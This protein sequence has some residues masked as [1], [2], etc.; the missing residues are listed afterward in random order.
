M[1]TILR[2]LR[3][4]NILS[5]VSMFIYFMRCNIVASP[6]YLLHDSYHLRKP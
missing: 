5:I 1:P 6:I 3:N 4:F 2:M